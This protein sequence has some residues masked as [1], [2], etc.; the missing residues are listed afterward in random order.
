MFV[1]SFDDD[2]QRWI[3]N[4]RTDETLTHLHQKPLWMT[5][6]NRVYGLL[7]A[8]NTNIIDIDDATAVNATVH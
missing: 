4:R 2:S 3:H 7:C 6:F 1:V 5:R 8:L